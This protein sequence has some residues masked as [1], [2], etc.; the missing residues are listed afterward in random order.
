MMPI[1]SSILLFRYFECIVS[2][3]KCVERLEACL[4]TEKQAPK[5]L[6]AEWGKRRTAENGDGLCCFTSDVL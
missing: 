6:D 5:F 3:R 1:G 4:K 2:F